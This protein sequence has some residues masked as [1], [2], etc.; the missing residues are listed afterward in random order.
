MTTKTTQQ[1]IGGNGDGM[2][3]K[4]MRI[5]P[6]AALDLLTTF[7]PRNRKLSM[8]TINMFA[9]DMKEG[10]WELNGEPLIFGANGMLYD[11]HHRLQACIE[12]EVPFNT[13]VVYDAPEPALMTIDIGRSRKPADILAMRG[14]PQPTNLAAVARAVRMVQDGFDGVRKYSAVEL[15]NFIAAHQADMRVAGEYSRRLY[16]T[17]IHP[18][19]FGAVIFFAG[20]SAE[21][22]EFIHGLTS[23]EN[24]KSGSPILALHRMARSATYGRRHFA[25]TEY[26]KYFILYVK[27]WNAYVEQRPIQVLRVTSTEDVP[28]VLRVDEEMPF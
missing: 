1:T 7:N 5:T 16:R 20:A 6:E 11:G 9:R 14:E 26:R 8:P 27:A 22:E 24:L 17:G 3:A 12:A 18:A 10:R 2:N 21:M 19:L 25:A 15:A 4:I 28:E 13:L 23:G